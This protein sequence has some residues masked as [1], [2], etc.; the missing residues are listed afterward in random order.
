MVLDKAKSVETPAV[1]NAITNHSYCSFDLAKLAFGEH[2][3]KVRFINIK[4]DPIWGRVESTDF[5]WAFSKVLPVLTQP[6]S[7]V[8]LAK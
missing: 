1:L 7:A 2:V 3:V 6:S 8:L 5:S 4:A